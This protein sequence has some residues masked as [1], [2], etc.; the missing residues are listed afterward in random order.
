MMSRIGIR[1]FTLIEVMVTTVILCLGTV[2]VQECLL[3]SANLLGRYAH[4]LKA[5]RWMSEKIWEAKE[6]VFYSDNPITGGQG[7]NFTDEGKE[8]SWNLKA[9]S[10]GSG[11]DLYLIE[12]EV[13]WEEGHRPVRLVRSLLATNIDKMH[14]S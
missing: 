9:D 1:G 14:V 13:Q 11:K 4:T 5:Q 10:Q 3:R 12:L 6:A 8:F 2:F 7:G